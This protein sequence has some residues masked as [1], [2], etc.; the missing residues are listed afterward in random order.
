MWVPVLDRLESALADAEVGEFGP[1]VEWEAPPDLGPL[2][3]SLAG[4]AASLLSRQ[5]ALMAEV[6]SSRAGVRRE[7]H[8]IQSIPMEPDQRRSLDEGL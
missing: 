6:R 2:P 8:L 1:L 7:L 3:E 5:E 4:R